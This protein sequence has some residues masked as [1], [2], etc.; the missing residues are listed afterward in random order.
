MHRHLHAVPV[1][2]ELLPPDPE[3]P[4]VSRHMRNRKM[5]R[6]HVEASRTIGLLRDD[7]RLRFLPGN[8]ELLHLAL[9]GSETRPDHFSQLPPGATMAGKVARQNRVTGT[10]RQCRRAMMFRSS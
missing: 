8:A 10:F 5:I 1:R 2:T 3:E 7:G 6:V 9:T 4:P